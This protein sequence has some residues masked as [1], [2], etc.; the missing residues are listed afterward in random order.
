MLLFG[1]QLNQMT[2]FRN[3]FINIFVA[4]FALDNRYIVQW[5]ILVH[6]STQSRLP[7]SLSAF[8]DVSP[9]IIPINYI[10]RNLRTNALYSFVA[11]FVGH[12]TLCHALPTDR[13]MCSA[14][15]VSFVVCNDFSTKPSPQPVAQCSNYT[16]SNININKQTNV[17]IQARLVIEIFTNQSI[18]YCLVISYIN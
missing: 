15:T 14:K 13:L 4:Q 8:A 7:S 17:Y 16:S 1:H 11:L 6:K 18:C 9:T 2:M 5:Y 10:V 12:S 3:S